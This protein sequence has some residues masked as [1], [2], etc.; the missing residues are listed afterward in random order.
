MVGPIESAMTT[1]WTELL[2]HEISQ[3]YA[4][5]DRPCLAQSGPPSR[6]RGNLPE[7]EGRS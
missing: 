7:E 2:G 1:I 5:H 4:Q 6:I 3:I